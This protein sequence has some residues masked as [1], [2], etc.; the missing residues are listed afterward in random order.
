MPKDQRSRRFVAPGSLLVVFLLLGLGVYHV[1]AAAQTDDDPGAFSVF[2]RAEL[3]TDWPRSDA[4][5]LLVPSALPSGA[6]SSPEVGFRL[7]NVL[8]DADEAAARRVWV[9]FYESD[10][11]GKQGASFRIFQRPSSSPAAEPCGAMDRSTPVLTRA[12]GSAVLSICGPDLADGS[13]RSYWQKVS[14]TDD[15]AQVTW[16]RN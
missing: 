10:V 1:A 2:T 12:V 13:A 7:D 5:P 14:F 11:L 16:L 15:L 6:E 3:N 9:S 4:F 8:A